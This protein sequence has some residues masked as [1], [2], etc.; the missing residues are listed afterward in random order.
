MSTLAAI[1]LGALGAFYAAW[2]ALR[3]REIAPLTDEFPAGYSAADA[4]ADAAGLR[5]WSVAA[6]EL[7]SPSGDTGRTA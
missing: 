1:A 4:G 5:D 7:P 2:P 6:G 3:M